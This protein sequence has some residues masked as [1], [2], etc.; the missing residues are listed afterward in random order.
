MYL[1]RAISII[2]KRWQYLFKQKFYII[3]F[4]LALLMGLGH[5]VY[6]QD[7]TLSNEGRFKVDY[8]K[9]CAP[10][11]V[12]ITELIII[13]ETRQFWYTPVGENERLGLTT[14]PSETAG[15]LEF[16]FPAPGSYYLVQI[17]QETDP[18]PQFDTIRIE[19][20]EP[21]S[22][23]FE[24]SNCG[25]NRIWVQADRE[26]SQYDYYLI[27]D[28]L[29]LELNSG[30]DYG[31]AVDLNEGSHTISV[32]GMYRGEGVNNNCATEEKLVQVTNTLEPAA[33]N[34][35]RASIE[36]ASVNIRY[37]L[38]QDAHQVLEMDRNGNGNFE[39]QLVLEN[40]EISLPSNL[41]DNFYCFRIRTDN[42]CDNESL[43]SN[44]VCT[45]QLAGSE[46]EGSNELSFNSSGEGSPEAILLRDGSPIHSFGAVSQGTYAD[47]DISCEVAYTYALSL[48]YLEATSITEGIVL[49][50]P[51]SSTPMAPNNFASS[52]EGSE[53]VL[54]DLLLENPAP[55][56]RYRA[57]TA[58]GS[59]PEKVESTDSPPLTLPADAQN[60]C[61]RFSYTDACENE[62]ALSEP[63]CAIYLYNTAREPDGLSL[64]WNEYTGYANGVRSYVLS[65][66]DPEGNLI[67]NT[68]VGLQTSINLGEQTIAES[69]NW[70]SIT[71]NPNEDYLKE[72]SSNMFKFE[73][74]MKGYF[75]N[76]F[77]PNG[78]GQNDF[79]KV[80]GKF[81]EKCRIIIFN[82]WGQQIYESNEDE[83]GWDGSAK[84]Q[85]APHGTYIYRAQ[86]ETKDG[87]QQTHQ[88]TVFL[89]R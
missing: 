14:P 88:G 23:I 67:S 19:V 52:W 53:T 51:F 48:R 28:N 68:S 72:S 66:Y 58:T 54:F 2:F 20:K 63:V 16:E 62:S 44:V 70:Y 84:G 47:E 12:E 64:E 43:Y 87:A 76:A 22:P 65:K 13:N 60:S 45:A 1:I 31:L 24:A 18:L 59:P 39:K 26:S 35:L 29:A 85:A 25:D 82:R 8:I 89:I 9:G 42:R 49:Q 27:N 71:A 15:T 21:V 10:L 11:T 6:A 61:Y 83:Q 74:V 57:Y 79:F 37:I 40:N 32:K 38:Q 3:S 86:V 78:D 33:I 7:P 56:V 17:Q 41:T 69:G 80:E 73:I 75:P 46:E 81:V 30:N 36:D 5:A 50:N 77:T 34:E 4:L 55:N